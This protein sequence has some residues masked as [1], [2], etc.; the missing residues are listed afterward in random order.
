MR[1]T[2]NSSW[3]ILLT[4]HDHVTLFVQPPSH[5]CLF[6]CKFDTCCIPFA[7]VRVKNKAVTYLLTYLYNCLHQIPARK[8]LQLPLHATEQPQWSS[9][10][11]PWLASGKSVQ[12]GTHAV[13]LLFHSQPHSL[14][15]GISGLL[16]RDCFHIGLNAAVS[17]ERFAGWN[18]ACCVGGIFFEWLKAMRKHQFPCLIYQ[19]WLTVLDVYQHIETL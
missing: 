9:I 3:Y 7:F 6:S 16:D 4:V 8:H 18:D 5:L 2:R 10:E 11:Y 12:N 1:N 13:V 19:F 17:S 15:L 14:G